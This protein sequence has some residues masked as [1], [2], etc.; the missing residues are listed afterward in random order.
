M[1]IVKEQE[2]IQ[3][4]VDMTSAYVGNL[5]S[6]APASTSDLSQGQH[7]LQVAQGHGKNVR[8]ADKGWL[9]V[10]HFF[11]KLILTIDL[12]FQIF[13]ILNIFFLF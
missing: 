13:W 10:N 4:A 12:Q 8:S 7:N 9:F 3:A 5:P 2:R 11:R 6:S 1:V